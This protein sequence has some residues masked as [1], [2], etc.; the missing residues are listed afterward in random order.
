MGGHTSLVIFLPLKNPCVCLKEAPKQTL[1]SLLTSDML[2][3]TS[4]PIL[5]TR[6][7]V[8]PSSACPSCITLRVPPWILKGAGMDS[9]GQRLISSIG[10]TKRLAFFCQISKLNFYN[11]ILERTSI[12]LLLLIIMC[13]YVTLSRPPQDSETG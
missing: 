10:K 6:I 5:D 4:N 2:D 3:M 11:P 1:R 7:S 12:L 8:R 9:S 13:I